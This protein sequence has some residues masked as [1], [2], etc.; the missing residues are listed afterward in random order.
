MKMIKPMAVLAVSVSALSLGAQAEGWGQKDDIL[1]VNQGWDENVRNT[2]YHAPQGSPIMPYAYFLALEQAKSRKLFN[3]QAHLRGLGMLYW[4]KS[5]LNPDGLPIGLTMDKGIYGVEDKL[6]MNCAACH[7]TEIK[8]G[9]KTALVDGGVSHFDFWSF[10][11]ELKAAIEATYQED[12]KFDRFAVRVLRDELN[13]DSKTHLRARLRGVMRVREDWAVRNTAPVLPGP[14]RV[15]ALNVILNQTTAMMLDRPD[16]ARPVDAPVSYPFLWDAPYM[17]VVQYN[18]VVPNKGAGALGRNVGQVLGVFGEVSINE[19]TLP[20]GYASSVRV[21]HLND[22]EDTL[23]TLTAPSWKDF[24]DQGLLPPVDPAL[25]ARGKTVYE[26]ECASCHQVIDPQNRG[27]LAS[28]EIP[29]FGMSEI[30]TDPAAAMGFAARAVAA[31]PLQGRKEGYVAGAPMCEFIHGNSVLAHLTVGVIMNDLGA[32]YKSVLSSVVD[33][34]ETGLS[35]EV[36]ALEDKVKSIFSRHTDTHKKKAETDQ[37]VIARMKA[38]G[39]SKEEI[40][41]ALET[42]N[43][44]ARALY[45]LLVEEGLSHHGDDASCLE[46]LET[47]QYRARPLN[48]VWATGPFLHNGSVPTIADLLKAPDD[49]P[50]IFVVGDSTLDPFNIGFVAAEGKDGFTMD[51]SKPGNLNTGHIY[52]TDLDVAD[53]TAILEYLKSL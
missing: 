31:G 13:D 46:T 41:A 33:E 25:A 37:Q 45:D 17:N 43:D 52:G 51:T 12:E 39:A 2:F 14:G 9:G 8:V 1:T 30:G 50:K 16:N 34:A 28:I 22:L 24:A 53:K 5:D 49:R 42:R 40:V 36:H 4:G 35:S 44:N 27:D 10:M 29:L 47:A 7:V 3:D 19:S 23:R 38:A 26:N 18:G 20:G 48:G 11:S 15:D 21:D 32:S 6:G